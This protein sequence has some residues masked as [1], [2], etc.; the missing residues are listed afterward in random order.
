MMTTS[1]AYDKGALQESMARLAALNPSQSFLHAANMGVPCSFELT[2]A[3]V[4][5]LRAEGKRLRKAAEQRLFAVFS[6]TNFSKMLQLAPVSAPL[7]PQRST[8]MWRGPA[9]TPRSPRIARNLHTEATAPEQLAMRA[10][11]LASSVDVVHQWSAHDVAL[12][13]RASVSATTHKRCA[14]AATDRAGST[15]LNGSVA[16]EFGV[17]RDVLQGF[18]GHPTATHDARPAEASQLLDEAPLG[19]LPIDRMGADRQP[20]PHNRLWPS[21]SVSFGTSA[22]AAS[23]R[24]GTAATGDPAWPRRP[25][26]L[27]ASLSSAR[28]SMSDA[29][30]APPFPAEAVQSSQ[31]LTNDTAIHR[32]GGDEDRYG[33]LADGDSSAAAFGTE[34]KHQGSC[35]HGTAQHASVDCNL[36]ELRGGQARVE[37]HGR[38]WRGRDGLEDRLRHI[39][40]ELAAVRCT[41]LPTPSV[42]AWAFAVAHAQY[43]GVCSCCTPCHPCQIVACLL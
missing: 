9:G 38:G 5:S 21:L 39:R 42:F 29:S 17:L 12:D 22:L 25:V 43:V 28:Q 13:A 40:Q 15:S 36:V 18:V 30:P 19:S 34:D 14:A 8:H 1:N 11:P 41:M 37:T 35:S 31:R 26:S 4:A 10:S 33:P 24:R 7:P 3:E 16:A 32:R 23:P 2:Q 6:S 20:C 27:L